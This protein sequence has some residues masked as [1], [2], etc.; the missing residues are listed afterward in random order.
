MSQF[1]KITDY[2]I[3]Y[4]FIQLDKNSQYCQDWLLKNFIYVLS[5]IKLN[6]YLDIYNPIEHPV[7]S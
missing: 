5:N 6:V 2:N 4:L 3:I 1:F 7:S